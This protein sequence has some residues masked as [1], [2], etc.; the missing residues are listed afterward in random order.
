MCTA[1]CVD[2]VVQK[3]SNYKRR[4]R[5]REKERVGRHNERVNYECDASDGQKRTFTHIDIRGYV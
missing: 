4:E 5:E 1:G 3:R 2:N